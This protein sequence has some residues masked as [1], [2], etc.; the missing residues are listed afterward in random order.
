MDA[1]VVAFLSLRARVVSA[2]VLPPLHLPAG[3]QVGGAGGGVARVLLPVFG[4]LEKKKHKHG[5]QKI[6][7][8]VYYY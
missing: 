7:F 8:P 4:A 1:I 5:I 6:L 3:H 2:R